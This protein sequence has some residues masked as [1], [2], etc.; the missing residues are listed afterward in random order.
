[1]YYSNI[2]NNKISD[3]YSNKI[4]SKFIVIKKGTNEI[5][6]DSLNKNIILYNKKF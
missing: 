3:I 6:I 4:Y 1:M 2:Y 5:F